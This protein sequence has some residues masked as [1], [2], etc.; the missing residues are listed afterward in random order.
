ME[1]ISANGDFFFG[2]SLEFYV[3]KVIVI[4]LGNMHTMFEDVGD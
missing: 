2:S 3:A 4:E 1:K